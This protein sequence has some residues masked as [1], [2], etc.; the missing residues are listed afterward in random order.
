MT[1]EL[2]GY[3]EALDRD[4]P[5][6]IEEFADY[7]LGYLD[8]LGVGNFKLV[9][10]SMGG[11]V[12]QEMAARAPERID[13]LV[14]YGTGPVGLLPGRFETIAE[15]KRRALEEGVEAT[16]RRT[17]ATWFRNGEKAPMFDLCMELGGKV[18]IQAVL[19]GLSAMEAWD[20]RSALKGIS[21]P[22]LVLWGDGDR[23]YLWSQP[24]ALWQGIAG[25]ELAVV[26]GCAHNVHLEK[27]FIFNALLDDFLCR[28]SSDKALSNKG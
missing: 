22:T 15:S 8:E 17:V 27:P 9:G 4:A 14:L 25:A 3:G 10:H 6:R 19:A 18:A 16:A 7:V 26:P 11:M 21:M 13:R 5:D 20:G 12:V 28:E 1:P 2:P 24:K 23:T